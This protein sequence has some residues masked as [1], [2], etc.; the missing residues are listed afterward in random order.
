MSSD[1]QSLTYHPTIPVSPAEVYRA[2]TNSTAL[3]EWFCDTATVSARPNGHLFVGWHNGYYAT[4]HFTE[5]QENRLVAFS[6]Q[7]RGEPAPTQVRVELAPDDEGARLMLEHSGIGRGVEWGETAARFDRAWRRSLENLSSVLTTGED[8]RVTRRPMLG[9][10]LANFSAD[11]ATRLGIPVSQ[12]VRL[13]GVVPQLGADAAGL[14]QDDV[15]VAIDGLPVADV[16]ALRTALSSHLAGDVVDVEFYRGPVRHD[17]PMVLSGRK[18][19]PIPATPAELSEQVRR[20]YL[21]DEA[22]LTEFL[23]G[24]TDMEASYQPGPDEWSVKQVL[25][26]LIQGERYNHQWIGELIGGHEGAY[27]DYSG[28]QALR[29]SATIHAFPT[30]AD[31]AAELARLN[32]ETLALMDSLPDEFVQRKRTYWRLARTFLDE[33]YSH[34]ADHLGQMRAAVVAARAAGIGGTS[35]EG[36]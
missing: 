20:R 2:F 34:I 6:W 23:S 31:M 7:G 19:P 5:L 26:H 13:N 22:A 25:A 9:I 1:L 36:A 11:D 15:I 29:L 24:I 4:G 33:S 3:R 27:D 8:L 35:A 14:R 18:I 16:I 17:T 21:R 10:L 30:V 28:N 32:A 12:G